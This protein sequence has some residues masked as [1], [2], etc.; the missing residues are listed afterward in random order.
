[1]ELID[2]YFFRTQLDCNNVDLIESFREANQDEVSGS[3]GLL[4]RAS[5]SVKSGAFADSV[6]ASRSCNRLFIFTDILKG[7]NY[8]ER[9]KLWKFLT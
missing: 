5:L 6:L 3:V 9:F 2:C 7:N 1:M 4:S 8:P